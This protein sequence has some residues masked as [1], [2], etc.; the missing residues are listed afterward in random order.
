MSAVVVA[1]AWELRRFAGRGCP[2][3]HRVACCRPPPRLGRARPRRIPR[4]PLVEPRHDDPGRSLARGKRHTG[5]RPA[6]LRRRPPR[7]S[8]LDAGGVRRGGLAQPAHGPARRIRG[9]S[10]LRGVVRAESAS[11][12]PSVPPTTDRARVCTPRTR[13]RPQRVRSNA[14]PLSRN[15]IGGSHERVVICLPSPEVRRG[16]PV[17]ASPRPA[18]RGLRL[19]RRSRDERDR[20]TIRSNAA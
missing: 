17:S 7:P 4:R 3:R 10:P 15:G 9:C 8:D 12:H 13:S 18:I 6:G 19:V 14:S 1:A 16:G 2:G 20:G 5:P 11:T